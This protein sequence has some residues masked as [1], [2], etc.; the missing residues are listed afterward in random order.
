MKENKLI[1]FQELMKKNK[2]DYYI[3]PT[4]DFHSSEIAGAYFQGRKYLSGFTGSAG[5][6][7]FGLEKIYLYVDGRYFIQADQQVDLSMI[8]VMKIGQPECIDMIDIF[9]QDQ[10]KVVGFDGRC[11]SHK[12]AASIKNPIVS[13]I[14][15]IDQVWTDRP[16]LSKEPVYNYSIEYCGQSRKEK[17]AQ[18]RDKMN[19]G[20]HIVTT[21]DD[22]AYIFNLRGNDICHTPVF[23]SYALISKTQAILYLNKDSVSET[24]KI[25]L[26]QDGVTIK[27]YYA[28]YDDAKTIEGSIQLDTSVVNHQ[29]VS[30]LEGT[31]VDCMN[32]SQLLK[33]IKNETEIS[34]TRIA[35]IKDGLAMTKFM[36]YL[37]TNI[38]NVAMDE[39]SADE[40]LTGYRQEQP[41]FKG[42]S[43]ATIC[44]YEQNAALMHYSATK[45]NHARLE[46]RG[47]LLIDS[48]G[49]YLQGTIDTT[50]TF[51]LGPISDVQKHHFTLVF[52][53]MNNLQ[54]ARFLHGKTGVG[55]DILA[56]GI[57]QQENLDYQCGTGH[58]V[59]HYLSV[60]EGPHGLRPVK[61][62]NDQ[63]SIFEPGMIVTDEP[64]I[65]L[66]GE[67]GIRLENELLVTKGEKNF[68]G[69]FLHFE[70]LT[71]VPI[72]L[73]GI[74]LAM[75]NDKERKQLCDYHQL[76]Y[77]NI[78]YGLNDIEKQWY[79]ETL[80]APLLTS[81]DK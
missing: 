10:T 63:D 51:V 58:G 79:Q 19:A 16:E 9:N 57:I 38:A 2:I 23:Y 73:D 76:V 47:L 18:I 67:Y 42:L 37:K 31:V 54:Q 29:I 49:Q 81:L 46:P 6:L 35:H 24:L 43:F 41:D 34:N 36:H 17:L 20:T 60:H 65:Y 7:L 62:E 53:A 45:E 78:E 14:D 28:I 69:Q 59:G 33:A 32:P 61:R 30:S 12:F 55:L 8:T 39:L 68:Y 66:A 48:G 15:L 21:L 3:V 77:S 72:D 26:E 25:E 80:I 64:G 74:N 70:T 44:A 27:D 11:V 75:L 1:K 5:T 56:R 40:I 52:Q 4:S 50:R 71:M 13:D 22:I